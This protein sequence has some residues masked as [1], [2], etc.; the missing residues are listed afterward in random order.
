MVHSDGLGV[1]MPQGASDGGGDLTRPHILMRTSATL[2]WRFVAVGGEKRGVAQSAFLY[3]RCR[4]RPLT[5]E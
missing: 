1:R 4:C 5:I 2:D 3:R